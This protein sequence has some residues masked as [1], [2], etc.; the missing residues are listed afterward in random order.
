MNRLRQVATIVLKEVQ[1]LTGQQYSSLREL[2]AAY[3]PVEEQ[4]QQQ[5]Q[6]QLSILSANCYGSLQAQLKTMPGFVCR[7]AR[8]C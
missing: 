3:T 2:A 6:Q 4:Q 7:C 5:P 8:C 1:R